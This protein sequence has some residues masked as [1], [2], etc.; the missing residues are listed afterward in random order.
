MAVIRQIINFVPTASYALKFC[1]ILPT[2]WNYAT[3]YQPC[4]TPDAVNTSPT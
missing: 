2:I 4:V 3:P 1:N